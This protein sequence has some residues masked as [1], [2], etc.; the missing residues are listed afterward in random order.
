MALDAR[1]VEGIWVHSH[2]EDG[3]GVQVYRP[4]TYDFP[5]A[6]GRESIELQAGGA[7]VDRGP[8]PTDVPAEAEGTWALRGETL[9]LRSAAGE[10]ALDV[11]AA[12]DD[13]LVLRPR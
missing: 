4:P 3:E 10:R 1:S 2:E 9:V 5:P 6:R 12:E 7:L 8:G 11:V 13:Q